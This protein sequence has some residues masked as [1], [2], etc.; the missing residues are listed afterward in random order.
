MRLSLTPLF[1]ALFAVFSMAAAPAAS[2]QTPA[3][4]VPINWSSFTVAYPSDA[5]A[6]LQHEILKNTNKYAVTTWYQTAKK[7]ADQ[8]ETHL[9]FGGIQEGS[10]R[11]S[12]AQAVALATS[13][14]LGL[15]DPAHSGVS[16]EE[17]KEITLKLIR[18]LAYRHKANS[19]GGWGDHW[20]SAL[21]ARYAGTAAWMLW[22]D[23]SPT[24]QE[25][26]RKMIEHEANFLITFRT[27]YYRNSEGTVISKGDSKAEE[28]S[29]RFTILQ[30]ATAMM[31]QRPNPDIW[32]QKC[33]EL[34]ISAYSRPSDLANTTV[35]HGRPA[36]DWLKGS[37]VEEDGTVINHNI[38]HPDYCAAV[39]Q[40]VNAANL[41]SLAGRPTPQAALFNA[42]IAYRAMAD[43]KF[44]SP[45]HLPPGGTVYIEGS[46]DIYYPQG[47]D[48][49][50]GR[51]MNYAAFDG[52]ANAFGLDKLTKHP[53]DYW[54]ALHALAVLKMQGRSKDGRN[55]L[56]NKE[57][58]FTSREEAVSDAAARV[59]LSK[60]II[61]NKAFS[62]TNEGFKLQ[63]PKGPNH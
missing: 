24:D 4:V 55:Y 43:V 27:P 19:E 9:N 50:T 26:V 49:G 6:V 13:L 62:L 33:L 12:A 8:T 39:T 61:A 28:N 34:M 7:F 52:M 11:P 2:A 40:N 10:I 37:N 38:I 18:S 41:Y 20:Q 63:P 32:M 21:W 56:S 51:R 22:A 25:Y 1:T 54:E 35:L 59:C 46:S 53:G 44:A 58:S 57:D 14:K 31:P 30:L 36:K 47:N 5:N 45:P 17:A 60:W 42:D 48:W 3:V 16:L 15:Y 29:W 23:L